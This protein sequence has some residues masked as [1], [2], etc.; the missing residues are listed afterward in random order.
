[1]GGLSNHYLNAK[2]LPNGELGMLLQAQRK[3]TQY[4]KL[5]LTRYEPTEAGIVHTHIAI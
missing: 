5:E 3:R 4:L 1:M 2:N